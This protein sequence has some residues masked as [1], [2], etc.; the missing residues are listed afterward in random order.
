[1]SGLEKFAAKEHTA[2]AAVAEDS[3]RAFD[4]RGGRTSLAPTDQAFLSADPRHPLLA[5]DP[6][7]NGAYRIDE[8]RAALEAEALGTLS[9]PVR[10]GYEPGADFIDGAGRPWSF[11]GT[12]P[13]GGAA[14]GQVVP[15]TLNEARAGRA[16]VADLRHL[17]PADQATAARDIARG[18]TPPHAEVRFVPP[19]APTIAGRP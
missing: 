9:G 6:G 1:M 14:I 13:G 15:V 16:V 2:A 19:V 8:A 5:F 10:R 18:L 17:S 12:R 11:K 3:M 4:A 7:G